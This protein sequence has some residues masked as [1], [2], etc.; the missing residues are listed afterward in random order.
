[1]NRFVK[2]PEEHAAPVEQMQEIHTRIDGLVAFANG[3]THDAMVQATDPEVTAAQALRCMS[4]VKLNRSDC[5]TELSIFPMRPSLTLVA[6]RGSSY[7]DT[8]LSPTYQSLPSHIATLN[9]PRQTSI[10]ALLKT[11]Q[12]G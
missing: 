11:W 7:T 6:V 8:V 4:I 5:P 10:W 1:M 12:S 9:K 3:K 2:N